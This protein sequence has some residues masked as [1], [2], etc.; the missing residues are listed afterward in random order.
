[1]NPRA[2]HETDL[3]IKPTNKKKKIAV[4][5][6]GPGGLATATTAAERGHS[7]FLYDSMDRIGGQLNIAKLIP[8]KEEFNETIRYFKREN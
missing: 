8:G 5:G 6:A 2:C 4:I 3:I 1:V 7:V